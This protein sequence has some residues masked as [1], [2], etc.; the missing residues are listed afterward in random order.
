MRLLLRGDPQLTQEVLKTLKHLMSSKELR[1]ST[2][3]PLLSGMGGRISS[4]F[5]DMSSVVTDISR[6]FKPSARGLAHSG[7]GLGDSS[8]LVGDFVPHAE[9]LVRVIEEFRAIVAENEAKLKLTEEAPDAQPGSF[10]DSDL[11]QKL[12]RRQGA[13][14][15]LT[16]A[17]GQADI[18]AAARLELVETICRLLYRSKDNHLEFKRLEGYQGLLAVFDGSL[19]TTDAFTK[20]MLSVREL[21]K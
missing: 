13:L 17:L 8:T 20:E 9:E 19:P 18:D 11:V 15:S 2:P 3:R 21:R 6:Y 12:M 5:N 14:V 10:G 16:G 1:R 7:N 4:F